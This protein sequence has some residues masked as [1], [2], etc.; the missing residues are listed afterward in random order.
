V[1]ARYAEVVVNVSL[2]RAGKS[3]RRRQ[4]MPAQGEEGSLGRAFHYAIPPSLHGLVQ[5]GHMVRV[6]FGPRVV[7]GIVVGLTDSCPVSQTRDVEALLDPE[8]V[9]SP[10]Q[11]ELALWMSD[12]YLAPLVLCLHQMLPPGI[13]RRSQLLVGLAPNAQT[14][15]DQEVGRAREVSDGSEVHPGLSESHRALLSYL[16]KRGWVKSQTLGR[17]VGLPDWEEA[18]EQLVSRDLVTKRWVLSP[19]RVRAKTSRF[20]RLISDRASVDSAVPGL[21]RPSKQSDALEALADSDDPLPSL[22]AL[23]RAAS[24]SPGVVRSL[25]DKGCVTILPSRRL[26]ET[27]VPPAQI[28]KIMSQDLARAPAQAQVLSYLRDQGKPL[29]TATLF[30]ESRCSR[31]VLDAL[32]RR[33]LIRRWQEGARVSLKLA[34]EQVA[35]AAVSLRR[36]G[37]QVAVLDLLRQAGPVLLEEVYAATGAK[38]GHVRELVDRGL[39]RVE[40][41]EVWRDPLAGQEFVLTSPPRLTSE[42]ES[43]WR[44]LRDGLRALFQAVASADDRPEPPLYLLH[45][46]TGSGKTELYLRAIQETLDSGRQAIALIPEIALTPQTIRRF[47]ARFPDRLAVVHSG[48]S[49]GERYDS[50]RRIRVGRADVVIGPRSALFA[51]LP[52]LGCIILDEEHETAYKQERTPCYHAREVAL[53]RARLEGAAVILGSATPDLGSYHRALKGQ[54]T[55][56]RLPQRVMGHRVK[57]EEQRARYGIEAAQI[58]L[59]EAGRGHEELAYLSLPPVEIVDLRA[60]LR[61]GNRSIFS[62]ALQSALSDTVEHHQQAILF[63]NRRGAATFV[64]CRD[65]G[66]VL[67]CRRC[68]VPLTY[69]THNGGRSAPGA[70]R[71]GQLVCHRCSRQEAAPE[72]CPRCGGHRIRYFGVGT[73][74]VEEALHQLFPQVQ[75]L[76]WDRDTTRTAASHDALLEQFI[77][78][79]ADVLI[80]TQMVAKGLDLPLVTLVGVISADTALNLP[81]FRASER[82]FQLLTQVAGR[83]GRSILGGRVIIQTYAPDHYA[84][85]AASRHDYET[86]YHQEMAFRGEQGYPPLTRLARLVYRHSDEGQCTAEVQRM[87]NLV[88]LEVRRQGLADVSLIGPAPCFFHRLRGRYRWQLV[89]RAPDPAAPLRSFGFPR[90][91][92][93]DIDPVGLL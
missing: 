41:R 20:L 19:P 9:V 60:E 85:Q 15:A 62:R 6:P 40:E 72:T 33:G 2:R 65:C 23:C 70:S 48:L 90:G 73:Q 35:E 36:A 82:T 76:R 11:I 44:A 17:A 67:R 78:H 52:R 66:L 16:G 50:W 42:Q 38:A 7:Q 91:W 14:T 31:A 87:A 18:L 86:F 51:P 57:V 64:L 84:I 93:V 56:L 75:T 63:L 81:D 27:A 22:D 58:R 8:P 34:P 61:A 55:L 54:F 77:S 29:E 53:R 69:H 89:L 46:V 5:V 32:E 21:G 13:S 80:G 88:R 92:Q 59:R 28:D 71:R 1:T 49:T 74:R 26:V 37:P 3:S 4:G 45:G 12:Y 30:R 39:V 10:A 83:A 79:K 25:A 43:A 68:D 47:A 24:C